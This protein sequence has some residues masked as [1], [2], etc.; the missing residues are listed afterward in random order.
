MKKRYRVIASFYIWED[1][2]Q[3]AMDTIGNIS[4]KERE[5]LDNQHIIESIEEHPFGK[6]QTRKINLNETIN[7][8]IQP[9]DLARS[10]K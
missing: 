6:W 10:L 1:S 5:K 2:D 4:K 8:N 9:D 3:E 7:N